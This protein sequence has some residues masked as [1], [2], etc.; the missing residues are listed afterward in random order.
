MNRPQRRFGYLVA[1]VACTIVLLARVAL[2]EALAE[3]ARLLP[4]IVAVM[5]AAWWGG[6]RPGILGSDGVAPRARK[7]AG[8]FGQRRAL[9]RDVSL[10]AQR[11]PVAL[12]P[13][14]RRGGP[15]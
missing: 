8:G 15:R 6:L 4:F 9:G 3:Q 10:A 13:G 1:V 5:A 14:P 7:L 11:R 12:A 2:N